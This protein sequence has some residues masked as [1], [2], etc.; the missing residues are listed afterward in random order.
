MRSNDEIDAMIKK[1]AALAG[2]RIDATDSDKERFPIMRVKNVTRMIREVFLTRNVGTIVSSAACGADLLALKL[3]REGGLRTRIVLPFEIETF[4]E[5]SVSDRLGSWEKT[6]YKAI[7]YAQ[8]TDDLRI[9][10]IDADDESAF[11]TTNRYL[12]SEAVELA[13][14]TVPLAITVWEGISRG[15]GDS[16]EEFRHL[17]I[18]DGFEVV[19]VPSS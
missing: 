9:L 15:K 13:K 6:F 5:I 3:A 8:K 18:S 19:N 2:R 11:S 7:Q 4:R 10:G 1:V 17:A 14:K 12:I 16:T